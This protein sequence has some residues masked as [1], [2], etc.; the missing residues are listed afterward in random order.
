MEKAAISGAVG[1]G[2]GLLLWGAYVTAPYAG[3][4]ISPT[5]IMVLAG[6]VAFGSSIALMT[7]VVLN[8]PEPRHPKPWRRIADLSVADYLHFPRSG[9]RLVVK[10]DTMIRE[11]DICR[12]PTSYASKDVV[13]TIKKASGKAIFNPLLLAE[14]FKNL[15]GFANFLHVLLVNEHDEFVGYI[16]AYYARTQMVG[17]Q[18]EGKITK[19]IIDVLSDP[20][21]KSVQLREIGGLSVYETISD[22]TLIT[23]ALKRLSEG[24]FRGFVVFPGHRNRKPIG[25][26]FEDA[27]VK[28]N[29]LYRD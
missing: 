13:L 16:P 19:Y 7:F 8:R 2:A 12:H 28:A 11:L 14:L 10:P 29:M 15:S 21:S 4:T 25:V 22:K 6:G 26:I 20:P 5:A 24:L 18:G 9:V 3:I 27:L 1:L 17:A 23:D